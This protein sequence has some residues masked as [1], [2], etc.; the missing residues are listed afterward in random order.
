MIPFLRKLWRRAHN[1]GFVKGYAN[2]FEVG[3][4]ETVAEHDNVALFPDDVIEA[5]WAQHKAAMGDDIQVMRRA[6]ERTYFV[7]RKHL[8]P[9]G[10]AQS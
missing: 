10:E 5:F 2:G 3:Q 7:L 1:A 8:I 9:E 6:D 4:L